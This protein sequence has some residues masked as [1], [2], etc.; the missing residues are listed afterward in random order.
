MKFVAS[1]NLRN[2]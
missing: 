1:T 2:I